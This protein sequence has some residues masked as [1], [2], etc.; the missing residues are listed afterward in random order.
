[1]ALAAI[2]NDFFSVITAGNHT[3]GILQAILGAGQPVGA[4][5]DDPTDIDRQRS[6]W[7][8]KLDHAILRAE[9]PV[10]LV[11]RGQSCFAATWWARLSPRDY[12]ARVAGALF[13]DP[14]EADGAAAAR[15]ASPRIR[16]PFPS[17]LLNGESPDSDAVRRAQALALEWGGALDSAPRTEALSR[18]QGAREFVM[19]MTAG[20]VD[21]RAQAAGALA[22]ALH[23]PKD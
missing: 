13:I 17:L 18:W 23:A 20:V 9:R 3:S 8:A 19:R 10:L 4:H 11:A 6:L 14:L 7:A 15:F 16:L 2:P 5:L 12:I 21:R 1:M 22:A